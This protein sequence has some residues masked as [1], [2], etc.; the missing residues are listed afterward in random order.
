MQRIKTPTAA[1][2]SVDRF[3]EGIGQRFSYLVGREVCKA[4]FEIDDDVIR[5]RP[6]VRL[7]VAFANQPP[8]AVSLNRAAH[9]GRCRNSNSPRP[10][11]GDDRYAD[12]ARCSAT[13]FFQ[14]AGKL[15]PCENPSFSTKSR[16]GGRLSAAFRAS[17]GGRLQA[18]RR[19]RPLARR[20][21]ITSLP[22]RDLMRTRNP[23]VL[24]LRR[25]LG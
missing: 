25:L 12:D 14:D 8:G 15:I 5:R 7:S 19:W 4:W 17:A 10:A 11:R 1:L 24:L 9:S 16:T 23:C 20:L 21:L 6:S 3:R 22:P 18:P 2:S 13:A